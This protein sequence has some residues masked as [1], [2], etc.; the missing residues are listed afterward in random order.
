MSRKAFIYIA[1]I[2]ASTPAGFALATGGP[3]ASKTPILDPY[4]IEIPYCTNS[5]GERPIFRPKDHDYFVE[6]K[7]SLIW[8]DLPEF[9]GDLPIVS[10]DHSELQKYPVQYQ[11]YVLYTECARHDDRDASFLRPKS[12]TTNSAAFVNELKA[13]CGAMHRLRLEKNYTLDDVKVI[14]RVVSRDMGEK[15]MSFQDISTR[16]NNLYVCYNFQR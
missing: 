12:G 8:T 16:I 10:Y 3:E 14:S 6:N 1:A 7:K 2:A 15:N 9:S 13:E 11:V 4:G 5:R